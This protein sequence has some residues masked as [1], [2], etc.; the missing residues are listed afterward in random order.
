MSNILLIP[1][2]TTYNSSFKPNTVLSSN[3]LMISNLCF[4]VY[5]ICFHV[6]SYSPLAYLC[7]VI[8]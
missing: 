2:L 6:Y 7:P 5:S 8:S 4:S 1:D 3:D